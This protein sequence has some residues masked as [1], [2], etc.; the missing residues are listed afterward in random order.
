VEVVTATDQAVAQAI[1]VDPDLESTAGLV[2][3][4][5][6]RFHPS[7]AFEERLSR[8]LRAEAM[9]AEPDGAEAALAPLAVPPSTVV[10]RFPVLPRAPAADRRARGGL[11]LGGAIASGVS[12]CGAAFIAWRRARVGADV[13]GEQVL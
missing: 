1:D 5:L 11:L 6:T 7:F 12:L 4:A 8:R 9:G 2:E 3:R 13:T 10:V